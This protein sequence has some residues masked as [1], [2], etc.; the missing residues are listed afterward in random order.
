L[1]RFDYF[2]PESL[3]EAIAILRERGDGGRLLAG[4]TDVLVQMKEAGLH[5]SYVVSLRRLRE[6]RGITF[7]EQRGLRIG[8]T[9]TMADVAEHATVRQ[10]YPVLVDG[11]SIV[12][13]VQTRNMATIGGNVC[14]AAPSADTAAPLLVLGA[15]AEI[16]GPDGRRRTPLEGFFTGPGRTVLAHDE[17]LI[18]FIIP[19]PA[20]RTGGCY[21]RHTPRAEMDIAVVGVAALVTL[22]PD[23]DVVR[24]ARV[25]LGAVAP[26]PLRALEAEASLAGGP[27][28]DEAFQRAAGL[29][30]EAARP[31]SDVRGSVAFR[32]HLVQVMA[33]RCLRRAVERARIWPQMDTDGHRF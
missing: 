24:E 13:S 31:I 22:E 1:K 23:R 9:T 17:V 11:A 16:A 28:S 19:T 8:A 20:P 5:P 14:N 12:G 6:L 29:A 30:A 32:R 26:T 25:A 27:P 3:D 15:Q 21:E 10:R 7:D 2:A 4:G 33:A 18:G